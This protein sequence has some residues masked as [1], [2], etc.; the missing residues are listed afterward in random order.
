MQLEEPY[1]LELDAGELDTLQR[2]MRDID[3][4]YEGQINRNPA[5]EDQLDFGRRWLDI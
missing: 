1:R 3:G 2:A 4:R 5:S